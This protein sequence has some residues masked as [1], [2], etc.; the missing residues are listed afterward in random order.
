MPATLSR[1]PAR[2]CPHPGIAGYHLEVMLRATIPRLSRC[3]RH[4]PGAL[5]LGVPLAVNPLLISLDMRGLHLM[6]I[7]HAWT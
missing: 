3:G 6:E 5:F 2:H 4:V 1:W 7:G